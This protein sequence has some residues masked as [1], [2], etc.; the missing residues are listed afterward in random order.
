MHLLLTLF[1]GIASIASASASPVK[2][3]DGG[4]IRGPTDQKRIA[5][6]F[7]GGSFAEGGKTILDALSARKAKASF[8]FTGDF[9]TNPKFAPLIRRIRDEGHYIGPH[10]DK[11]LLY[12][13]WEGP[14]NTLVTHTEF[15]ADLEANLKKLE[16]HGIPRKEIIH[17]IPPY[18]WYNQEI[19]RWSDALGL[20]LVNFTPG[21]RSNADYTGEGDSNFVSSKTIFDSILRKEQEDA[22][23]LNGFL[24][25]LHIGAG[26]GR[27][28]KFHLRFAELLD[29]LTGKGY[30]FVRIDKLLEKSTSL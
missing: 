14:K 26:P 17:W 7:T 16:Q 8:Y 25:L 11:H 23:G 22:H 9:L 29:E 6:Q 13:P 4:I 24:L 15:V 1:L 12:C 19:V 20:T 18:E 28:D 10:S 27:T 30:Q 5:L 3:A 21:T 2:L